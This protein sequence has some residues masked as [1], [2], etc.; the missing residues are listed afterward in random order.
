MV[1]WFVSGMR[2][3]S[4]NGYIIGG[5]KGLIKLLVVAWL[6][7]FIAGV[8]GIACGFRFIAVCIIVG[9]GVETIVLVKVVTTDDEA[10][11]VVRD[12]RIVTGVELFIITGCKVC[13][14]W[15]CCSIFG[16]EEDRGVFSIWWIDWE[17]IWLEFKFGELESICMLDV[18]NNESS[19]SIVVLF[20]NGR[21]LSRAAEVFEGPCFESNV[22]IAV[23]QQFADAI[24]RTYSRAQLIWKGLPQPLGPEHIK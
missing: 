8:G 9:S 14:G 11:I 13:W 20:N 16:C 2:S 19:D 1:E 17:F 21:F 23:R 12:A 4:V 24:V 18:F 5:P 22:L 6:L 7:V 15:I 10:V 3:S